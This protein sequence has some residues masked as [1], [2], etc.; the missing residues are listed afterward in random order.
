MIPLLNT[1]HDTIH[2]PRK[3]VMGKLQP[4]ET[5]DTEVSNISW[6]KDDTDTANSLTELPSMPPESSFQP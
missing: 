5:E 4:I 3:T 6:V 1:E 2:A